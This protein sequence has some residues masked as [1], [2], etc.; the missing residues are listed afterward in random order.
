MLLSGKKRGKALVSFHF[1]EDAVSILSYS[2]IK[3]YNLHPLPL[4]LPPL[5]YTHIY[6][7]V[8]AVQNVCGLPENP[9]TITW[10]CGEPKL[11]STT[12]R[13]GEDEGVVRDNDYESVTLM[14]LRQAE[15]RKR[16][17]QQLAQEDAES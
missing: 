11:P 9:L 3:N 17:C 10:V 14:R 15:E 2:L 1:A 13:R 4:P 7:Q 5:A 16:L 6:T 8:Q 12:V